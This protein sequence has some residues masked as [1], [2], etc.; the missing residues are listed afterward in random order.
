M[1]AKRQTKEKGPKEEVLDGSEGEKF[2]V[3]RREHACSELSDREIPGNDDEQNRYFELLIP[4]SVADL[5][6]EQAQSVQTD[7]ELREPRNVLL[8]SLDNDNVTYLTPTEQEIAGYTTFTPGGEES[9]VSVQVSVPK[10]T[11]PPTVHVRDAS[12]SCL[13]NGL[14]AHQ[15]HDSPHL[16]HSGHDRPFSSSAA[17]VS[18]TEPGHDRSLSSSLVDETFMDD[19]TMSLSSIDGLTPTSSAIGDWD[20]IYEDDGE[21]AGRSTREV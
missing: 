3:A 12:S 16:T 8:S 20:Y 9:P 4:K 21:N 11:P 13:L 1:Q 6:A 14:P 15:P 19:R 5:K 17:E 2:R 10:T 7:A 18:S